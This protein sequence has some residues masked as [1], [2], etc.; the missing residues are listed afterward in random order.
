MVHTKVYKNITLGQVLIILIVANIMLALF[1]IS[2]N[3]FGRDNPTKINSQINATAEKN[4]QLNAATLQ[5]QIDSEQ[6]LE[7]F[8]RENTEDNHLIIAKID[9]QTIEITNILRGL[10]LKNDTNAVATLLDHHI[11]DTAKNLNLTILNRAYLKDTNEILHKLLA[12]GTLTARD[13][14]QHP[15]AATAAAA[16]K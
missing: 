11:N 16:T 4:K 5:S 3:L 7:N 14:K 13:I 10:T 6:R 1:A 2:I 12:N 8:I 9:Q 15:P